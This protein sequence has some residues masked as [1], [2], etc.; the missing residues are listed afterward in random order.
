MPLDSFDIKILND[1][2]KIEVKNI[3]LQTFRDYSFYSIDHNYIIFIGLY[4]YSIQ[5]NKP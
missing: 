4:K 2:K 5:L 1:K 3:K